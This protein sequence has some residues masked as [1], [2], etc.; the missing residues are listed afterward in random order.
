M[1][2]FHGIRRKY[3]RFR[4]KYA[5]GHGKSTKHYDRAGRKE[6]SSITMEAIIVFVAV[7][8]TMSVLNRLHPLLNR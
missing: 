1:L 6:T 3:E 8:L 5:E 7:G 4:R 2:M